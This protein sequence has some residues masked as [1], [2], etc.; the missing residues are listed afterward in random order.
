[1][2]T[3]ASERRR[4]KRPPHGEPVVDRAF[5]VLD[6]FD[7][8]HREITLSTLSRRSGLPLSTTRRLAERLVAW[9][10]LEQRG[11]G[12]FVIGLRL[13]EV[14]SLAPRG[15]GLREV[16]APYVDDLF[17]VT[18]EHVQLAVLDGSRVV[19]IERRSRRGAVAVE[20]RV[21]GKLP[22]VTTALGQVL[23]AGLPAASRR[24]ALGSCSHPDDLVA[25][26]QPE[27]VER[28]LASVRRAGVAIVRR[29]TPE[30]IVAVAAPVVGPSLDVVAALS[31][32]IPGHL[33]P[34]R[35]EPAVRTAARG[36][37]RA[38]AVPT[39]RTDRERSIREGER[40][41][42]R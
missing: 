9:G 12:R 1:M 33:D 39:R 20:Y 5:R 31:I 21:G 19:L 10:A 16:A 36:I 2:A 23:V 37:G 27:L 26:Q 14:A 42:A 40:P 11:D 41:R 3:E 34:E 4:G 32:V 17:V 22:I 7:S 38:L 29:R 35:F 13:Y 8:G 25:L 28:T 30:S 6:A 18:R 24:R 15:L